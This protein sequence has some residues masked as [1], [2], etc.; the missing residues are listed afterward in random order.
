MR[1]DFHGTP[2]EACVP[3][4]R[5]HHF[6]MPRDRSTVPPKTLAALDAVQEAVKTASTANSPKAQREAGEAVRTAVGDLYDR[7]ESTSRADAEHH[8]EGY[9]YARARFTRALGEAQ[10]A[11][12]AMA[13]HAQ[14]YA[15]PAGVGFP[16]D[17]QAKSPTVVQLHLIDDALVNMP[18]A[19]EL[20]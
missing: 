16:A 18:T 1:T 13:D 12:Q 11:L 17:P 15:N 7:A 8:R 4:D 6:R 20:G 19:P 14:Q 9:A 2:A 10:A 5:T 3:G